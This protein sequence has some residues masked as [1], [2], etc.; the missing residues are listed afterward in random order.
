MRSMQ[1]PLNSKGLGRGIKLIQAMVPFV[2]TKTRDGVIT[3]LSPQ[4]VSW[5]VPLF[6]IIRVIS[7]PYPNYTDFYLQKCCICDQMGVSWMFYYPANHQNWKGQ[8]SPLLLHFHVVCVGGG[9]TGVFCQFPFICHGEGWVSVCIV[10][11][12]VYD[13]CK[14][15]IHRI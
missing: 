1:P 4:I 10:T 9:C 7:Q 12:L 15:H 11:V 13:V 14:W 2:G 5:T 6:F 3:V 8:F